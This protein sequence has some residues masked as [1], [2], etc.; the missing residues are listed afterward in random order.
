MFNKTDKRV[1]LLI[2]Q[3]G[4]LPHFGLRIADFVRERDKVPRILD[5]NSFVFKFGPIV[6]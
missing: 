6:A 4:Q 5:S 2:Y 3:R 1:L